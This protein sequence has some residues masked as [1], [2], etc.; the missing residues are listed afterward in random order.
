MFMLK[1]FIGRHMFAAIVLAT[2]S[3]TTG[4]F[5]QQPMRIRGEIEKIDG[6]TLSLKTREGPTIKVKIADDARL[7]TLVKASLADIKDDNFIGVAGMPQP[8]GSIQAFSV[9]IFMPAQRGKIPDRHGEWDARPGSTMT[10][11][12]VQSMVKSKDGEA[13]MVKYKDGEKKIIMSPQTVIA[14]V[15]PFDKK[16]LKVGAHVAIVA[17]EKQ[18]DGSVLAKAMYVGRDV[19]PAM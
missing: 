15:A 8:D 18:A 17:S 2:F 13:V 19:T 9:H 14:A 7:G 11:A 12:Y 1:S 3:F 4:A 10:N 6:D 5:A 16:D